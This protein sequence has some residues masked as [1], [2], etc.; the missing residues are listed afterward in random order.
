M[1]VSSSVVPLS[2]S[3]VREAFL[4]MYASCVFGE[5]SRSCGRLSLQVVF[6]GGLFSGATPQFPGRGVQGHPSAA[7]TRRLRCIRTLRAV[8][9][10]SFELQSS[11]S[12]Q[13]DQRDEANLTNGD[14][15]SS[16]R[17]N[18]RTDVRRDVHMGA[19]VDIRTDVLAD[20]RTD[21]CKDVLA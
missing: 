18:V 15:D 9:R 8:I 21:V 6:K 3:C 20:I 17:K 13:D 14:V 19:R 10:H 4:D 12:E 16:N 5:A 2:F 7:P 11:C 1:L